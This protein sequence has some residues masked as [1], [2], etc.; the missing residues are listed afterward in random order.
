[1]IQSAGSA[2]RFI[3]SQVTD[4]NVWMC[5]GLV[6]D[7]VAKDGFII[8]SDNV[9]FFDLRDLGYGLE[10]VFDDRVTC[11]LEKWL[12]AVRC[13]QGSC[14]ECGRKSYF[15]NVER[16]WAKAGASRRTADLEWSASLISRYG[17]LGE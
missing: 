8:V 5:F 10:A 1:M 3:F 15:G 17:A 14:G 4:G 16:Q 6:L 11:D 7:E 13:I 12:A 9:D 2:Q